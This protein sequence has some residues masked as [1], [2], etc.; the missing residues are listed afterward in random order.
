MKFSR[1]IASVV[2]PAWL[3]GCASFPGTTH[4]LDELQSTTPSGSPFTQALAREYAAF[5]SHDKDEYDWFNSWHFAHKGLMAAHGKVVPP[6][7]VADWDIA[8]KNLPEVEAGHARLMQVL[9]GNAPS[10]VPALTATAQVKYD[11]WVEQLDKGWKTDSI[12]TCH[13]DFMAALDAIETQAKPGASAAPSSSGAPTGA[14]AV[15]A[16]DSHQVFFDFNA[17]KLSPEASAIVA[18]IAK[19]AK[20]AGYPK[21]TIV[22]YTDSSGSGDYNQKLSLRRAQAVRKALIAAGVPADHLT[23][24]GRGKGEPLVPTADGVQEPQNRRVVVNFPG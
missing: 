23:A 20:E 5:A 15:K 7:S 2:A 17:D 11:C 16:R 21:L 14:V 8:K 4:Y 18:D 1:V 10:R 9:A 24:E 3:V 12:A 6:E 19:A 22:G 13:N